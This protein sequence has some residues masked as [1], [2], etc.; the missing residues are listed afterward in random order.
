M[1]FGDGR[2][3]VLE[4]GLS[5]NAVG[6]F[7]DVQHGTAEYRLQGRLSRGGMR[8]GLGSD[9]DAETAEKGCE[10]PVARNRDRDGDQ[11]ARREG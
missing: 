1:A 7:V 8:F 9:V 5:F 10:G 4:D 2:G 11:K 6:E 3:R